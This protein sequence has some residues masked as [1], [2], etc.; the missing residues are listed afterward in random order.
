[1]TEIARAFLLVVVGLA[2]DPDHAA[3]FQKWGTSLAAAA[4]ELGVPRDRIQQLNDESTKAD[5][6]KA[7]DGIAARAAADDV[8]VVVL[9]GHGSYDGRTAKFNLKGPDM[10]PADFNVLLRR[11]KSKHVVLANTTSA[12]GPFKDELTGPGRTIITATRSGAEQYDTLFAGFFVGAFS[13]DAADVDKNHRVTVQEAFDY[14]Q[15]EVARTYEREGL[16]ATEH[17]AID[18]TGKLASAFAFGTAGGGELSADPRLRALQMER[19]DLEQRVEALKVLKSSMDPA[20]YDAELERL[21][22]ALALKT[23]EIRQA[24]GK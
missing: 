7:I 18:D 9:I 4:A 11:L 5:V 19:R 12:S 22:T 10:T 15:R 3:V 23:R 21:V 17:A 1:M 20:R 13:S 6:E 8:V 14:A 24:D 16:L 2:G